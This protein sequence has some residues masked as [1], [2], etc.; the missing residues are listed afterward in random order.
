MKFKLKN[1]TVTG[2]WPHTPVLNKSVETGVTLRGVTRPLKTEDLADMYTILRQNGEIE[3]MYFGKNTLSLEWVSERWWLFE[4]KFFISEEQ[5]EKRLR[6]KI[7][8]I[9]Y[10]ADIHINGKFV[11]HHKCPFVPFEKDINEYLIYGKENKLSITVYN[12][13][14]E[15][16]QIGYTSETSTQRSRFD[17][18]WDFS[19]RLVGIGVYGPAYIEES[20]KA[21]ISDAFVKPHKEKENLWKIPADLQIN[22]LDD[23]KATLKTEIIYD[24]NTIITKENEINLSKGENNI[25]APVTVESP[26]LW[27]PNR[28]GEQ[29]IYTVKFTLFTGTEI[30]HSKDYEIAFRKAEYRK[31]DNSSKDSLPYIPVIN[32]EDVYIKGVNLVPFDLAKK[33]P[34]E[35]VYDKALKMLKDAN[36]NL[37]RVWGGGIL[38]S[39]YFYHL[40]TKYG[41]MVWQEFIQ[42]S[43]GID[44]APCTE[45]EFLELLKST[46]VSMIKQRRNS[47]SLIYWSG[48]N[49]LYVRKEDGKEY[50]V[51]Y[52]N[53]NIEMLHNLV[54][55]Y[56]SDTLMLPSSPSGPNVGINNE[57][58]GD[59]HDVHGPWMYYGTEVHYATFN[60]SD[61]IL[62]SEFGCNGMSDIETLKNCLPKESLKVSAPFS[63]YI[64]NMHGGDWWETTERDTSIFGEFK[65]DELETLIKCSQFIQAEGLRYALQANLRRAMQNCGSIIWQFNE[66]WPNVACTSLTSYPLIPKLAYY[67]TKDSFASEY[68]SLKYR[69]LCYENGEKFTAEVFAFNEIGTKNG[70]V[71]LE[72]TDICGNLLFKKEWQTKANLSVSLGEIE[73]VI[74]EDLSGGF[75]VK[76]YWEEENSLKN[77]Y[78]M[79]IKNNE[80]GFCNKKT[81]TDYVERYLKN[82][83]F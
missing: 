35:D 29:P 24:G 16:A 50:P 34:S 28:H 37:V 46:A 70:T 31:A 77:E 80:T 18:K 13:P 56:D 63:D 65:E 36:I 47:P 25:S 67:F 45:P 73:F 38:E 79:L 10:E 20:G 6:L 58:K 3:D 71:C 57:T 32:G 39:E 72:I 11:C 41:I 60:D 53:K 27:W 33:F 44:N 68:V 42:S 30:S 19:T 48:G 14:H 81:V 52:T 2:Y 55:E 17:Y 61:S 78:L 12:T 4:N 5:K 82:L 21:I 23:T 64:W 15:H 83:S 62:H 43:S 66:P 75:K 7:L 69:K 40:C 8:G 22:S 76:T 1:W 74:P 26:Q 59:N 49:E 9:D 54:K 51:D